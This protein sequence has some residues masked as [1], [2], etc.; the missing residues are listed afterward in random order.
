M[1]DKEMKDFKSLL[2]PLEIAINLNTVYTYLAWSK[3]FDTD[4]KTFQEAYE[5]VH[6]QHQAMHEQALKSI[7]GQEGKNKKI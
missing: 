1:T 2:A 3:P 5:V 4:P 6:K 7:W